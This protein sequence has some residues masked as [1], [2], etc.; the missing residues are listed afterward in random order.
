[1][2]SLFCDEGVS[3]NYE[4][5]KQLVI[6]ANLGYRAGPALLAT[7]I[8]RAAVCDALLQLTPANPNRGK[9]AFQLVYQAS[10]GVWEQFGANCRHSLSQF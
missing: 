5:G 3:Q 1:M 10:T 6:I 9:E 2:W 8:Y 4:L 7:C